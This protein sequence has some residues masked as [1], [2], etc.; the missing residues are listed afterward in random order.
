MTELT[1]S[2][3]ATEHPARWKWYLALGA[4]L[5]VLGNIS[6]MELAVLSLGRVA[7]DFALGL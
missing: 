7:A 3:Q 6:R 1:T 5:L 4:V 2:S